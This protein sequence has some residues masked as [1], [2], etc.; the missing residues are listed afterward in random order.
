MTRRKKKGVLLALCIWVAFIV[1]TALVCV[2]DVQAIGPQDTSVGFATMNGF[3]HDLTG[4]KTWLYDLTDVLGLIPIATAAGFAVFGLAQWV[5]RKS[6]RKVDGDILALGVFYAIVMAVFVLFEIVVI[7]YRPVLIEGSLEAS[8]PSSTT[9]LVVA[10]M[11]TVIMQAC[12][13][14]KNQVTKK[15]IVSVTAVFTVFMVVGRLISGVHWVSDIIGG[16]LF[17]VG[18][19]VLYYNMAFVE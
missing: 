10:V 15:C 9:M 1:W 12:K 5:Q 14:V 19:V 13:R 7:N 2:V 8:Y 16:L 17:S 3:F 4:M 6:I 11:P 18:A